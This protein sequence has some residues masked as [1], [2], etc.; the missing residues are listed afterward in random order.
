MRRLNPPDEPGPP[1]EVERREVDA[2][3]GFTTQGGS[4]L[5]DAGRQRR[6]L[7]RLGRL[8]DAPRAPRLRPD[9]RVDRP[10]DPG[11]P[12]G[13]GIGSIVAWSP[14]GRGPQAALAENVI[15]AGRRHR[16]SQAVEGAE[17]SSWPLIRW[18]AWTCSTR[19][20]GRSRSGRA[21]HDQRRRQHEGA[22]SAG[23]PMPCA[24]P[25]RRSPH[26]R[27]RDRL[28]T[29]TA[30]PTC[31]PAGPGCSAPAGTARPADLGRVERLVRCLRRRAALRLTAEDARSGRGGD[32]PPAP[33]RGRGARRQ[34]PR[35]ATTGSSPS[36]WRRAAG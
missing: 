19:S 14:S 35:P 26:G 21:D 1:D 18:P 20:P 9:R 6:R 27:R 11:G 3:A 25:C 34:R 4:A 24:W 7:D 12:D 2:P 30:G 13:V 36:A 23:G 16:S 17:L 32:L 10:G 33:G 29:R 5:V 8:P 22:T 31:S 15:D 28:A